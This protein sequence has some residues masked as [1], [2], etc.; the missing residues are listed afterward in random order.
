MSYVSPKISI[1]QT[2]KTTTTKRKYMSLHSPTLDPLAI[3]NTEISDQKN[4]DLPT[5][6]DPVVDMEVKNV[7]SLVSSRPITPKD[8]PP[9][10]IP[11]LPMMDSS[12]FESILLAKIE[13][14][15]QELDYINKDAQ[16]RQ[17]EAKFK[18]LNE[19]TLFFDNSS[20][21]RKLN[22]TCQQAFFKMFEKTIF[23]SDPKF[24][25]SLETCNYT[26]KVIEPSW[27]HL[28]FCYQLLL[29]FLY[30][31][32]NAEYFNFFIIKKAIFLM[33][34]PDV[35]ERSQ[36][37]SFVKS[38]YDSHPNEQELILIEIRNSLISLCSRQLAPF[39]MMSLLLIFTHILF[40]RLNQNNNVVD[41]ESRKTFVEGALPLIGFDYIPN[42]HQYFKS[43]FVNSLR[44][45]HS[46]LYLIIK[47]IQNK[48]PRQNGVKIPLILDL[49]ITIVKTMD[50][51]EFSKM[52]SNYFDFLAHQISTCHYK[53]I[54]TIISIWT[55]EDFKPWITSNS[56]IA[57]NKMFDTINTIS[58]NHWDENIRKKFE[59]VLKIMS[60]I[61]P[62]E[63]HKMK[64]IAKRKQMPHFHH[65][66]ISHHDI[67]EKWKFV[68]KLSGLNENE[69]NEFENKIDTYFVQYRSDCDK[70]FIPH[71]FRLSHSKNNI[72]RS[73]SLSVKTNNN[74]RITVPKKRVLN[75]S[76]K[77]NKV[78]PRMLGM[79]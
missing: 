43:F 58:V 45:D 1:L 27:F 25:S 57:I 30:L 7:V 3:K 60:E 17:K 69:R 26:V 54:D 52:A 8:S 28:V 77:F 33:Q 13:I 16:Q 2:A 11:P 32:P 37:V 14:C 41:D 71:D 10:D 15:S 42:Q 48:W 79:L 72:Y 73:G 6:F 23:R 31:F 70:R 36:L 56:S 62:P 22:P 51:K 61:N 64:M 35:N 44:A 67:S 47:A 18:T 34:L 24:P 68:A 63:Y 74:G 76:F 5:D 29:R 12:D 53:T 50:Q 40:R 66:S 9:I 55:K 21:A 20:D 4:E 38:Y 46:F 78:P 65:E 19:F 75:S 59:N 49:L 39:C